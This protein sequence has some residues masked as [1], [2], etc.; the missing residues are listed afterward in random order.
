M[1]K[2]KARRKA[3]K[4]TKG[5]TISVAKT[6]LSVSQIRRV[7]DPK[8]LKF[9]TTKK[10]PDLKEIIGQD[11]AVHALTFGLEI[12]NHGYHIFAVGQIGT[13]KATTIRKYLEKEAKKQDVP[14][15]W[16]YVN[17]FD[18][19]D[20][21]SKMSLPAGKG[22]EFRDDMDQLVAELK[23]EVPKAFEAETYEKE[24]KAIEK[25]FQ[26]NSEE[27]FQKLAKKAEAKGFRL[28][29]SAHGFAVLPVINKKVLTPEEHDKLSVKQLEEIESHQDEVVDE[30]QEVMREFEQLQKEA[31]EK[32]SELD[33]QVVGFS[34]NYLVSALK[35][36]YKTYKNVTG[37][38]NEVSENL[39]KNVH[40][41]KQIKQIESAPAQ[42]RL[43]MLGKA[44][45]LFE[46]YKVNLVV[47]NSKTEG[48]PVVIEKNPTGPNLIGRIEQQGWLGTL[49]T[50][51]RM[52]KSGALH[53]ANGGYLILDILDVLKK[54]FSWE[55]LKRSLKNREITIESMMESLGA[56]V[57]RT[58]EPEPIPL[59]IKVVL[60]GNPYFYY[61]IYE[62]DPEF[63]ELFKVKADF[64]SF[65]PWEE[66]TIY[67]YAQFINM[68]CEEEELR[69]FDASGVAKVVEYGARLVD[70]QNKIS[71]RF[72]EIVDLV[73]Q[74]SYWTKISKNK[75]VA[76]E[77]VQKALDEKIY[78]SNQVEELICEMIEDKTIKISTE[79]DV[80]GQINGLAV[81]SLG[82]YRF[83][84]P[85][86]ITV[87]TFVGTAGFVSIEREAKMG[88]RIHNKAAM[89]ISGY[90]GGKYAQKV[91]LAFSASLTFEQVYEDIE[92][93]S[94]SAAE[95]YA[96]LSSFSETPIRQDFAITGS[97]NQHG[98]VQAIGGA[99]EKIEGFYRVCKVFGLT[100]KQGVIIPESN[101]KHLMLHEDV[102]DAVKAGKFHIHAIATIDEGIELLMGKPAGELKADG[103]YP[104]GTI[105]CAVQEK[106]VVLAKRAKE[107]G[108][109]KNDKGEKSTKSAK[110]RKR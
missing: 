93:D 48:A 1:S 58:L 17:N 10:L 107:A 78:R 110:K 75:L 11:R 97:V 102:V 101:A 65:M 67:Q 80:V 25:E 2:L 6:L 81:L 73:R 89:I 104:K 79:G 18:D 64:A 72:G 42:E 59:D 44:E 91:P 22:R 41:F 96:L 52:I 27:L 95:I 21:P 23:T 63:K 88:G 74:A 69:H 103:S 92:G 35:K 87:Q 66:K 40:T 99:N 62:L 9:K 53:R 13:G 29:Q 82:D 15:D 28:V 68:V 54:P 20:K 43:L 57:T 49:I 33:K 106:I 8:S 86:R 16:L 4:K 50:N 60:V 94:A 100:G 61:L 12:K 51:F 32:L 56:F 5:K 38:L 14:C 83:G 31:R 76:A 24:Y 108:G 47:D 26:D 7:C 39:L 70:D 34:V 77:D 84:K 30:V 46:E 105:N 45:P 71:T 36:K 55:V 3:H 90:L 109:K 85:S 37:F 19:N 98:E